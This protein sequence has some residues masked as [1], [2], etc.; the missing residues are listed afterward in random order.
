MAAAFDVVQSAAEFT[1]EKRSPV[2]M[3]TATGSML[4]LRGSRESRPNSRAR[5]LALFPFNRA[6]ARGGGSSSLPD[7]LAEA[8]LHCAG[9]NAGALKEI[10]RL[11]GIV[12]AGGYLHSTLQPRG[13]G[14][15]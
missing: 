7:T 6:D 3:A 14:L 4:S 2:S 5:P 8:V 13:L 11:E 15:D 1:R 12:S 9:R 10:H